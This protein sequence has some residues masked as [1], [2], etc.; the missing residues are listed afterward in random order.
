MAEEAVVDKQDL[1]VGRRRLWMVGSLVALLALAATFIQAAP[2]DAATHVGIGEP[3]I[4]STTASPTSSSATLRVRVRSAKNVKQ[5]RIYLFSTDLLK[6]KKTVIGHLSRAPTM[7]ALGPGRP[8][9]RVRKLAAGGSV[10]FGS[11]AANTGCCGARASPRTPR[12]CSSSPTVHWLWWWRTPV[13]RGRRAPGRRSSRSRCSAPTVMTGFRMCRCA[14]ARSSAVR[15]GATSFAASRPGPTRTARLWSRSVRITWLGSEGWPCTCRTRPVEPSASSSTS[16]EDNARPWASQPAY[17][18]SGLELGSQAA[19][20][21]GRVP[22]LLAM[23][24]WLIVR[25]GTRARHRS[26]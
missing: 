2:A 15:R 21:S 25:R 20:S 6:E 4:I 26:G 19:V 3:R 12:P 24:T 9:S 1:R 22:P 10:R 16:G 7:T 13:P 11:S 5:V 18:G 14:S 23:D 17:S 8:T